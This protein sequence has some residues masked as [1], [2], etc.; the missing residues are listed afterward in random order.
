LLPTNPLPD[1]GI[2]IEGLYYIP[3]CVFLLLLSLL[4]ITERQQDENV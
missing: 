3:T 2:Y 4:W 1:T